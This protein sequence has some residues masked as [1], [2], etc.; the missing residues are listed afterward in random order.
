MSLTFLL[1]RVGWFGS[2]V[3][4]SFG[5]MYKN[6]GCGFLKQSE[7]RRLRSFVDHSGNGDGSKVQLSMESQKRSVKKLLKWVNEMT[8]F[9]RTGF[10]VHPS[11]SP[12]GPP[13]PAATTRKSRRRKRGVGSV[14][15]LTGMFCIF[16]NLL[17]P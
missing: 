16:L 15:G 14:N 9:F 13:S 8:F 17:T 5:E 3:Y 11:S 2:I 7:L 4:W 12:L 10:R 1:I 6:I